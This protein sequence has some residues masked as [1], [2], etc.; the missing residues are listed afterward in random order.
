[1]YMLTLGYTSWKHFTESNLGQFRSGPNSGSTPEGRTN[2]PPHASAF[3]GGVFT[4]R[5]GGVSVSTIPEGSSSSVTHGKEGWPGW[6]P[7]GLPIG[8]GFQRLEMR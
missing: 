3:I 7:W 4:R 8:Q 5:C 6:H 1:M 2:L